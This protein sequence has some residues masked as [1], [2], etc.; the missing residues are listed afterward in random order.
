MRPMKHPETRRRRLSTTVSVEALNMLSELA[1]DGES[2]GE[3]IERA[4]IV[5]RQRSAKSAIF[6]K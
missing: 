4:L 6:K 2:R 5:L 3:T 1:K